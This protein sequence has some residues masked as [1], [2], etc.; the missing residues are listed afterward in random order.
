[1]KHIVIYENFNP[2]LLEQQTMESG[3]I[4]SDKILDTKS[5]KPGE[6]Y[7]STGEAESGGKVCRIEY[8]KG[9][10][11]AKISLN[12]NSEGV[13]IKDSKGMDKEGVVMYVTNMKMSDKE[14][15]ETASGSWTKLDAQT[16]TGALDSFLANVGCYADPIKG[17]KFAVKLIN[18]LIELQK[19]GKVSGGTPASFMGNF[20]SN[21]IKLKKNVIPVSTEEQKEI[22]KFILDTVKV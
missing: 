13:T 6:L 14:S 1:M 7:A 9:D 10:G 4:F 11:S 15:G 5:I 22:N 20:V 21:Q 12:M 17:K 16:C 19:D 18:T 3:A 8:L 2:L